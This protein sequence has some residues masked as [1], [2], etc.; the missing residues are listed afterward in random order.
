VRRLLA[1]PFVAAWR[2]AA[3]GLRSAVQP[4]GRAGAAAA[5]LAA[6]PARIVR[7]AAAPARRQLS[8]VRTVGRAQAAAV[9]G[10]LRAAR[11]R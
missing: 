7:S 6:V 1:S 10:I 11:R 9:R 3:S 5:R 4:I 8:A 2:A